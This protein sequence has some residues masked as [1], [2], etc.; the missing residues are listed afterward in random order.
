M[1]RIVA[2]AFIS[3]HLSFAGLSLAKNKV[4]DHQS[5]LSKEFSKEQRFIEKII[6]SEQDQLASRRAA[7]FEERQEHLNKNSTKEIGYTEAFLLR[8]RYY[9]N[10]FASY[11]ELG[12]NL[13]A[14]KIE[15]L[16]KRSHGTASLAKNARLTNLPPIVSPILVNKLSSGS[17]AVSRFYVESFSDPDD[18]VA[19]IRWIFTDGGSIELLP[20]E[21]NAS[22][23]VYYKFLLGVHHGVTL[24][25]EDTFGAVTTVSRYVE[26]VDDAQP[27]HILLLM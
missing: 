15:H 26:Y 6:K 19:K 8:A 24:E 27:R 3:I 23:D 13:A 17:N 7:D 4:Y 18:S 11:L 10:A 5:V 2:L 1:F 20:G 16:V 22:A 25:V 21:F 9:W 14:A 12:R